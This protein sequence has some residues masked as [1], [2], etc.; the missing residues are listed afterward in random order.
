MWELRKPAKS[1]HCDVM[2]TKQSSVAIHED[3]TVEMSVPDEKCILDVAEKV[4]VSEKKFSDGEIEDSD[5]NT[6]TFG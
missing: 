6:D 3:N 5:E 1:I 2:E 4:A